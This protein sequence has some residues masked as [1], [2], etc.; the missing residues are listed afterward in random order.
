M[1]FKYYNE[2]NSKIKSYEDGEMGIR[3]E[4]CLFSELV[5]NGDIWDMQLH[6]Q[7]RF[8]ALMELEYLEYD[9]EIIVDLDTL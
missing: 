5:K 9:G 2:F 6:Y 3:E 7:Q 8:H 4:V 1:S